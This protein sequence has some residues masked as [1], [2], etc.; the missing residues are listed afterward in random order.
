[1]RNTRP[2]TAKAPAARMIVVKAT[3]GIPGD[4]KRS[5]DVREQ[6]QRLLDAGER[7]LL[8]SSLANGKGKDPAYGSVKTLNAVCSVGDRSV[9]L[10]GQDPDT[11]VLSDA[12]VSPRIAEMKR[13][14]AG[15]PY[16]VLPLEADPFTG[17]CAIPA[18]VNLA[19]SRVYLE[20]DSIAPEEAATIT[21]NGK[22]AGGFI[23]RPFRL[24]V[25]KWLTP[26]D[27]RIGI[28]PFAPKTAKLRIFAK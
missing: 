12:P 17:V 24:E 6:L 20:L 2:P 9:T 7:Q 16:T 18:E 22:A 23:G 3:Y 26:G 15:R 13:L 10:T 21:I 25:T 14:A 8:V 4:A 28:S 19:S 11:V 27:N 1:V 5:R